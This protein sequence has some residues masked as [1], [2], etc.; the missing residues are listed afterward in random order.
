MALKFR[1]I[2]LIF[3][4]AFIAEAD[5]FLKEPVDIAMQVSTTVFVGFSLQHTILHGRDPSSL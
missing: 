2:L 1:Y 3:Y 4:I 5:S